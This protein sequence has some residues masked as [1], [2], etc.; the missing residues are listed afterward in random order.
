MTPAVYISGYAQQCP[1]GWWH[2]KLQCMISY[3]TSV[4]VG[5]FTER[6]LSPS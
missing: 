4:K 1:S 6:R 2:L 3:R 5:S